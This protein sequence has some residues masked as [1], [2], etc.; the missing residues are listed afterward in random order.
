MKFNSF[1]TIRYVITLQSFQ[2]LNI[3]FIPSTL[4]ETTGG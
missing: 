1:L 4:G 2:L 3:Q